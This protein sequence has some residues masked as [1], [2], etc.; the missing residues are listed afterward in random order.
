M[1]EADHRKKFPPDLAHAIEAAADRKGHEL[2]VLDLR[3]ISNATDY[4]LLVSGTSDIHVRAVAEAVIDRLKKEGV[5]PSHIEGLRAGRWVLI[6]YIDFVVHVFHPA[7]RDF[8]RLE[9]L[10]GDATAHVLESRESSH[11]SAIHEPGSRPGDAG[12]GPS[13]AG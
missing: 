12:D 5:R 1:R 9:R 4:F 11:G 10:W 13:H 3:G 7:A 8:Y 6:D 2:L